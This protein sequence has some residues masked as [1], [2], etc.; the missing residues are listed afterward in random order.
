MDISKA[1]IEL[2]D[3]AEAIEDAIHPD[4]PGGTTVTWTESFSVGQEAVGVI[5][6]IG[7]WKSIVDQGK[8]LTEEQRLAEIEKIKA[9]TNF[10]N[11]TVEESFDATIDFL[12]A[13]YTFL[14]KIV[15]IRRRNQ[16]DE[17]LPA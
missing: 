8:A 7:E 3:V 2:G 11:Q 5:P 10:D 13:G 4:G 15:A 6:L 17:E 12:N 14:N 9:E 16:G 1:V